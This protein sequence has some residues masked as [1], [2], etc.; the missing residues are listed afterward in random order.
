MLNHYSTKVNSYL[1]REIISLSQKPE[2]SADVIE[3]ADPSGNAYNYIWRVPDLNLGREND[4][5][6]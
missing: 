4:Y 1:G 3:E 2:V 6:D 5:P